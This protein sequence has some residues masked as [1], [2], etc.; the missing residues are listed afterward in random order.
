MQLTRLRKYALHLSSALL[1]ICVTIGLVIAIISLPVRDAGLT[2]VVS[3]H[4]TQSGVSHPVTAV[5][6]NFRGYDTL[7]EMAVLLLALAGTWSLAPIDT[8]AST[9][10]HSP[11]EMLDSLARLLTPVI[12]LVA[13]YLLWAGAHAPG[14][15]FQAGALLAALGVMILLTGWR[16]PV[17][18]THYF[19]RTLHICGVTAFLLV[20]AS[21]WLRDTSFLTFPQ[22]LAGELI[23]LIE[24]CA[25]L[26]I[27]LTLATLF[28]LGRSHSAP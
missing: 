5:L 28:L 14:G 17:E 19:P 26:S 20:G 10:S 8:R 2:Q 4:L 18:L 15:A 1:V 22:H 7:L 24:T 12:V 27:G 16:I 3:A 13:G 11:G 6:L 9:T 25:M 21:A 23:L